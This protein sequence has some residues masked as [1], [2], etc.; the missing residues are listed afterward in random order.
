M[1]IL[2]LKEIKGNFYGGLPYSVSWDFNDGESPS[3]L[4]ISVVN[5]RGIYGD[6]DL[7]FQK[8]ETI[9]LDNFNFKGYLISFNLNS[10]VNQKT[11][12]LEYVDKSIDLEKYFVVLYTKNAD[13]FDKAFDP[14][15]TNLIIVGKPYHPCDKNMDSTISFTNEVKVKDVDWCDPCPF[16]PPDKYKEACNPERA[17]FEIFP[18]YYTFNELINKIKKHVK[19][20]TIE[21]PPSL[22]NFIKR[23]YEGS[24]KGVLSSWCE[25]LGL[26]Y[27]FDPVS[28]TLKFVDRSKR[29]IQIRQF[30]KTS[31]EDMIDL[32]TSESIEN[33]FSRGYISTYSKVGEDKSYDCNN[34]R[35]VTVRCLTTQDLYIDGNNPDESNVYIDD[36]TVSEKNFLSDTGPQPPSE[37]TPTPQQPVAPKDASNN[38][39]AKDAAD[40]EELLTAVSY[41]GEPAHHAFAWFWYYQIKKA[42]D[43]ED[44]YR[45]ASYEEESTEEGQKKVLRYFGN[46]KI[47]EVYSANNPDEAKRTNFITCRNTMDVEKRSLLEAECRARGF[48]EQDPGYYFMVAEF[49][50]EYFDKQ[51]KI[52]T[53]RAENFLGKYWHKHFGV[54]FLIAGGD[55]KNG[56][57]TVECPDGA[58]GE[59]YKENETAD[60]LPIFAFGHLEKSKIGKLFEDILDNQNEIETQ[61]KTYF[62]KLKEFGPDSIDLRKASSAFVLINREQKWFPDKS[63][64]S[65]YE[66]LFKWYSDVAPNVYNDTDGR[67]KFLFDLY[68]EAKNNANIKIFICRD[69]TREPDKAFDQVEFSTVDH[70]IEPKKRQ[71]YTKDQQDGFGNTTVIKKGPWG[72]NGRKCVK[73]KLPGIDLFT[74]VQCFG[75]NDI[76]EE[77]YRDLTVSEKQDDLTRDITGTFVDLGVQD[78]SNGTAGYRALLK[79]QQKFEKILPKLKYLYINPPQELKNVGKVDYS[80]KD[81]SSEQNMEQFQRNLCLISKDQFVQL[82]KKYEATNWISQIKPLKKASFKLAG[83]YPKK[84]TVDEGLVS[85]QIT[86]GDDGVYTSYQ[87]EDKII[88]PPSDQVLADYMQFANTSVPVGGQRSVTSMHMRNVKVGKD[89]ST[90]QKSLMYDA[91]RTE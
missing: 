87:F 90:K 73:I 27:Y 3:K 11:L 31:E 60:G 67:P 80:I 15:K 25:E 76:I 46:M 81:L 53:D 61:D 8:D 57:I 22:D 12:D 7:S 28:N 71:Q 77:G 82:A 89:V 56:E 70:P 17:N 21:E 75:N 59:W 34:E 83:S 64:F 54:R 30:T 84:Y 43:A 19:S 14:L 68:P 72:L 86:I 39:K 10:S 42:S 5:E 32:N 38:I 48:T 49:N 47:R 41:L 91:K 1:K 33:T 23:D 18:V 69:L 16:M 85:V 88:K 24:L 55:N 65:N 51:V 79:A 29:P 50:E 13:K 44:K 45:I 52:R 40:V 58:T 74:P 36:N 9:Q 35:L 26:A 63:S 4:K 66:S 37:P 62:E 6:P 20:F 78:G 2:E